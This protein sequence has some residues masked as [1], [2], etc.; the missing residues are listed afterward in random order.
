MQSL[1]LFVKRYIQEKVHEF[2]SMDKI[3]KT[4]KG[5]EVDSNVATGPTLNGDNYS[6]YYKRNQT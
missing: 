5:V 2:S 4:D 1:L 3:D 6:V